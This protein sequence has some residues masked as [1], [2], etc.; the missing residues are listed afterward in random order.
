MPQNLLSIGFN[1]SELSAEAQQVLTIVQNL[2]K[3][4]EKYDGMKISPISASGLSELT[5]SIKAQQS[6]SESLT[7][8]ISDMGLAFREYNKIA[9]ETAR[10]NAKVAVSDSEVAKANAAA[11]VALKEKQTQ[12]KENA[13][14]EDKDHQARMSRIAQ[15]KQAA[16]DEATLLRLIAE[17]EAE[18]NRIANEKKKASDAAYAKW[19]QEQLENEELAYKSMDA[20]RND[21]QKRWDASRRRAASIAQKQSDDEIKRREAE[22]RAMLKQN[23]LFNQLKQKQATLELMYTNAIVGGAPKGQR[24][25]LARQLTEANQAIN[26]VEEALDKTSRGGLAGFGKQLT[27]SLGLVRQLAYILPGIGIAGIFNLAFEAIGNAA[28]SL[29]LFNTATERAIEQQTRFNELTAQQVK[30]LKD[31]A[32]AWGTVDDANIDYYKRVKAA[33]EAQGFTYEDQFQEIDDLNKAN[34]ESADA[35]VQEL[36]AT[37]AKQGQLRS[38]MLL[39]DS[40]RLKNL[41]S[42][43]SANKRLKELEDQRISLTTPGFAQLAIKKAGEVAGIQKTIE[44]YKAEI[45]LNE[46]RANNA[47]QSYEDVTEALEKQTAANAAIEEEG[48]KRSKYLS[49]E[50]R[51]M[52]LDYEE[53]KANKIKTEN[54]KILDYEKSTET[55]RL[56]A[57]KNIADAEM[58]IADAKYNYV[59]TNAQRTNA[60]E[61]AAINDHN[62]KK[63]EIDRKYTKDSAKIIRDFYLKRTEYI[64]LGAQAEIFETQ[65]TQ[66]K[67]FENEENSY[68]DRLK[69]MDEYNKARYS[70]NKLQYDKDVQIARDT[71]PPDLLKFELTKLENE[72][73][74][75]NADVT[76]DIRKQAYD[77]TVGW[78]EKTLKTIKEYGDLNEAAAMDTATEELITLTESYNKKEIS[79]KEYHEE[80]QRIEKESRNKINQARIVDD[81]EELSRLQGAQTTARTNLQGSILSIFLGGGEKAIGKA[82]GAKKELDKF[83]KLVTDSQRQLSKDELK[84]AKDTADSQDKKD[85]EHD[86]YV[87]QRNAAYLRLVEASL[88]AVKQIQDDIFEERMRQLE[89]LQDAY[90]KTAEAEIAAIERSTLSEKEK[91]AYSIQLAARKAAKDEEFAKQQ[92]K[93]RHDQAVFDR[94]IAISQIILG[95]S[96]AVVNALKVPG[97]GIGLAIAV[98]AMGAVELATALATK[99][100]AYAL[101]GTHEKGGLALFGEAGS[102]LVAEPNRKPYIADRPTIRHLP[103][104]T[105]LVP[106]Y[107][108]PTFSE[109]QDSSWAQTLYLGKQ[110]AKS[111]REIKNIFRPKIN[112]DLGK[113]IYM[114]RILNG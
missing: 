6:Q 97:A 88:N 18:N 4:L 44:F 76:N 64:F 48:L 42:L 102:E 110:I 106:L 19:W 27:S 24:D 87:K 38:Q 16:K 57:V 45:A 75:K 92:K 13:L 79:F 9:E 68:D 52:V 107:D 34:K 111:K 83:N 14:A 66:K 22:G 70:A 91:N 1:V 96:V 82:E 55:Q 100:P 113:Q 112:I 43:G 61:A 86:A 89:E 10:I 71:Q 78:F 60:E 5:A 41:E 108:I 21:I 58:A 15:E 26:S 47:K 51:K 3:E 84:A 69:A 109:K 33:K 77:I 46:E 73:K 80:L 36:G 72:Y 53:F 2:Y 105:E 114:N 67:I 20:K 28:E 39:I 29:G 8:V 104:G 7:K 12:L 99:I 25:D 98:G 85:Q 30:L 62:E 95:T 35:R 90:D 31:T 50:K 103:A 56:N 65:V 32:D 40:E 54:E 49:D 63:L 81:K 101:G 11:K 37:Y 93:L 17:E 23:D 94:E 59:M 74:K